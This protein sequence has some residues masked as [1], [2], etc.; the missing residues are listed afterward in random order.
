MKSRMYIFCIL[1]SNRTAEG[2]FKV[3]YSRLLA[4]DLQLQCTTVRYTGTEPLSFFIIVFAM[5]KHTAYGVTTIPVLYIKIKMGDRPTQPR[6]KGLATHK[7][8][9]KRCAWFVALVL[10]TATAVL[11][12][13]QQ[14]TFVIIV[15][16]SASTNADSS[17]TP[18]AAAAESVNYL[19]LTKTLL[20]QHCPQ[21]ISKGTNNWRR[22]RRSYHFQERGY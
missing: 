10:M 14:S 12:H 6:A 19:P 7:V 22:N 3:I 2:A 18:A 15:N 16:T 17:N 5:Q 9:K 13:R 21:W 1:N 8:T 11:V 4:T 20:K